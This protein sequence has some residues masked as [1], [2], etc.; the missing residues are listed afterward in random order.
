[1]KIATIPIGY[2]DG[3]RREYAKDGY[4]VINGQRAKILGNICMDS[5]MADVTD[6]PDVKV[7]DDVYIWDN[8]EI[9]LEDLSDKCDTINYE[10]ISQIG[11]RV[12]RKFI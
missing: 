11:E 9:K 12:P 10:I 4:V 8:K 5:F 2:A 1:M 7:G 3:F 6:I